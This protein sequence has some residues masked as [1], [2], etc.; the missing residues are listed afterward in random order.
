[1]PSKL[2]S[3]VCLAVSGPLLAQSAGV[4]MTGMLIRHNTNQSRNSSANPMPAGPAQTVAAAAGYSYS[5]DAFGRGTSGLM[6]ALFPNPTPLGDILD[7][8][9]PG[10]SKLLRG[11]V[12]NDAGTIPFTIYAQTFSGNLSG[13]GTVVFRLTTRVDAAGVAYVEFSNVS[14]PL[15]GLIVGQGVI[16]S[17]GATIST[18]VPTPPVQTEW[19]FG[20]NLDSVSGS[21]PAKMRYL[22]DPAFGPP[23]LGT[24]PDPTLPT[25]VTQAQSL[26]G[27]TTSFGIP[28]IG[29]VVTTVYKTSPT[30]NL[31]DP[32]NPDKSRPIGLCIWPNTRTFF[33]DDKIGQWTLVYDILIPAAAWSA[34]YPAALLQDTDTNHD[35]ADMFIRQSGGQGSIGYGVTPGEYITSALIQPDAWMRVALVSD[36]YSSGQGRLFVNGQFIG[37]T[38]GD[39]V[40]NST[41]AN[42]P[43]YGDGTPVPPASWN[44]WGQ[45]PSPWSL[46]QGTSGSGMQATLSIFSDDS[47]DG[48]SVYIKNLYF[49]DRLMTDAQVAA[50][51]G[52]NAAGIVF[53]G[54]APCYPNCDGST[55]SPILNVGDFSCFLNAFASGASYANCDGSTTAP[56]LNV[57]DFSCFLNAFA[58]G[59]S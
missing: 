4:D 55:I 48:E 28:P 18:W 42:D 56:V 36:G 3:F 9:N 50:L 14:L 5:I 53:T 26:F 47:G 27:T 31:S 10:Q 44:A 39:W 38:G 1:M 22:D 21:G 32:T 37:T 43:K 23:L 40:Y 19:H 45:F 52:A 25:G 7:Y 57:Q 11:Y 13:L 24:T 16:T 12:R 6:Q 34:T 15:G 17:G 59:C 29:G 54:S 51:G 49:T 46:S 35:D 58:A 8:F 30:R 20:G 33:P 41:N 2:A